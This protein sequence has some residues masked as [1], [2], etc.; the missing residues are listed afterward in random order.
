MK[1]VYLLIVIVCMTAGRTA[2]QKNKPGYFVESK[3]TMLNGDNAISSQILLSGGIQLS[4]W[5]LGLGA[6]IDFYQVRTVPL[7]LKGQYHLGKSKKWTIWSNAGLNIAWATDKQFDDPAWIWG[8]TRQHFNNGW[9]GEGGVNYT[10]VRQQNTD[11]FIGAGYSVKTINDQ[12]DEL[13]YFSGS[14]K[15]ITRNIDYKFSRLS[16]YFGVRF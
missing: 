8:V 7:I 12:Y 14:S 15:V 9:I 13:I 1:P 2:A 3:L 10:L 16:L 5:D 6:G 4:R 11:L